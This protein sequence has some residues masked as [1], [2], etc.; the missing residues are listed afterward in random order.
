[1]R[2]DSTHVVS[3]AVRPCPVII[4]AE[5]EGRL[6]LEDGTEFTGRLFGAARSVRGEV[7]G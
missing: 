7:G 3:A 4:A 5:M 2:S 1:M 6:V